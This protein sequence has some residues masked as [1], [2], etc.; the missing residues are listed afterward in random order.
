MGPC[1]S[2]GA[3]SAEEAEKTGIIPAYNPFNIAPEPAP[4]CRV[5]EILGGG[6]L[7]K[8]EPAEGTD[9]ASAATVGE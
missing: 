5:V 9:G 1:M 8:T 6:N 7:K 2:K 4:P 3:Q